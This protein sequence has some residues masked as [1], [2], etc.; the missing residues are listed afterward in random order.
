MKEMEVESKRKNAWKKRGKIGRERQWNK[1]IG[2]EKNERKGE[3]IRE[4]IRKEKQR[5]Y[6]REY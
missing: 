4:K 3:W 2:I 6:E 5:K 1:D